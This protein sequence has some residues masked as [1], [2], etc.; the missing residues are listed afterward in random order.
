MSGGE[1]AAIFGAFG[2]LLVGFYAFAA[3]QMKDARDERK[4]E[5][6]EFAKLL[7][8]N[9][10]AL[11]LVS[12]SSEKVASA[13]TKAAEEAEKRNGH[14]GDQNVQIT[15]LI[16]ENSKDLMELTKQLAEKEVLEQNVKHQ[17]VEHQDVKE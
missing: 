4:D 17:V 6:Q 7:E 2:T 13:T 3:K 15:K 8:S 12:E 9:T 16:T 14:L 5:R 1:L 10:S 11:K